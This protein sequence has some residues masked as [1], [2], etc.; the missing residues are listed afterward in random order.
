MTIRVL[1]VLGRSAG[2]IARHVAQLSAGMDGGHDFEVDV[3]AP[4][5]LP[6]SFPKPQ[7][8][9][10]IPNGPLFGHRGAIVRL[11]EII[12]AG[13]YDVV[14][15]HG[16]RAGIDT[17]LAARATATP[18]ILTVHNLVQREISGSLKG[19]IYRVAEPLAVRL[20]NHTFAV[21]EEIARHLRGGLAG[22][23][24]E[25]LYLG[26]GDPPAVERTRTQTRAELGVV[27]ER[28]IVTVARLSPQKAIDV[29]LDALSR[30]PEDVVLVVLGEGELRN[31]LEE[32]ARRGGVAARVHF[33][34]FRRDVADFV[35]AADVFCLS[36]VWEGI[37]LAVQEAIVLGTPV[38]ST[39]V[40][41]MRE[42]VTDG[43]SG[44]LVPRGDAAALAVALK[45]V[46]DEPNLARS[47][48]ERARVSL[49][50][51]FSTE[52]MLA[53]LRRVYRDAAGVA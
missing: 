36:S 25:V 28:L 26:I 2:G 48:A 14:H 50:E 15:A 3:A 33:L 29:M 21:S 1:Q 44:R 39:D 8:P 42:I 53:R 38:V 31:L 17:S 4:A 10:H 30:L 19:R 49:S 12:A 51:R 16:L 47:L 20:A 35:A 13:G 9:V 7:I 41:G 22:A 46:L 37:P 5:D 27:T 43:V 52:K 24:V 23:P 40:G 34:G 11:R 6:G 32:H 18:V 45:D